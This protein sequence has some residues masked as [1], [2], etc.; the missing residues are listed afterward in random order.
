MFFDAIRKPIY[1]EYLG[2]QTI[3]VALPIST[4]FLETGRLLKKTDPSSLSKLN[5]IFDLKL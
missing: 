5:L 3:E 4:C 2:D 1:L